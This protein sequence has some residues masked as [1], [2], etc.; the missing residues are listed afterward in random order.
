VMSRWAPVSERSKMVALTTSGKS[1][2]EGALILAFL[3]SDWL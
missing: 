1:G 2:T 3:H